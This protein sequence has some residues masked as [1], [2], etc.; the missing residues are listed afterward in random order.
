MFRTLFVILALIS[1]VGCAH[2]EEKETQHKDSPDLQTC[3]RD[4]HLKMRWG[5]WEPASAYVDTAHRQAFLGRYE[6]KGDDF[7]IVD[8]EVRNVTKG[9]D[10]AIVEVEQEWYDE[11]MVVKKERFIEFW[12]QNDGLWMRGER[13]TKDEFRK[14]KKETADALKAHADAQT[15]SS[16]EATDTVESKPS[17]SP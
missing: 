4:H 16:V 14:R 8:I 12:G 2:G 3:V 7:K 15:K 6:E 17:E 10:S 9:G 5:L 1:L 11:T 13:I